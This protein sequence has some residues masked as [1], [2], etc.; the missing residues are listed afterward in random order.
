LAD[1]SAARRAASA[2]SWTRR[3][4]LSATTSP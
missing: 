2:S 1:S 4:V 3:A